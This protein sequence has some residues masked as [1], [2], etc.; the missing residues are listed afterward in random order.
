MIKKKSQ[1]TYINK[2][3]RLELQIVEAPSIQTC[4]NQRGKYQIKAKQNQSE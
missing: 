4:I 3:W 2:A 1:D